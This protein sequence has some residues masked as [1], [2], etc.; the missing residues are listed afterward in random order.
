MRERSNKRV[1]NHILIK[2]LFT[3][4]YFLSSPQNFPRNDSSAATET[5]GPSLR[6]LD[7]SAKLYNPKGGNRNSQAGIS[8]WAIYT[9]MRGYRGDLTTLSRNENREI[10]RQSDRYLPP[11]PIFRSRNLSALSNSLLPFVRTTAR[12]ELGY[13]IR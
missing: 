11:S 3:V 13:D 9:R 5:T 1:E 8:S 6:V 4:F 7:R 2:N 12:Y 10:T